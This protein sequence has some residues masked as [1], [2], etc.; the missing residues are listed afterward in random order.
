MARVET[1]K[2]VNATQLGIELGRVPL[3]AVSGAFVESDAVD[4]AT[5]AAAVEAHVAEDGY[6]DPQY[7]APPDP[8]AEFDQ[9]LADAAANATTAEKVD[10]LIAALRGS[11]LP[12]KAAARAKP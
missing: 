8:Q 2:A 7:V 3:R 12:A 11:G 9:A 6:V 10:A 5:L 4:E 1:D